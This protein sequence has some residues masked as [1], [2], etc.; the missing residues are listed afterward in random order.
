MRITQGMLDFIEWRE[1]IQTQTI[2]ST[3]TLVVR[4]KVRTVDFQK[5]IP[6]PRQLILYFILY[7]YLKKKLCNTNT[8]K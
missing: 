4:L 3:L 6:E 1:T 8:N 5:L 2:I 7:I